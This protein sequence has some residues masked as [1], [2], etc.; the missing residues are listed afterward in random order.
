ML[1]LLCFIIAISTSS[2]LAEVTAKGETGFNLKIS[3]AVPVEPA[4]AY[5]QFLKVDEWW[6]KGHTWFG[7]AENLSIDASAGGCFCEIDGE[8]QVHHML[9]TFVDPSRRFA[10]LEVDGSRRSNL[11]TSVA[12]LVE[13]I[14]AGGGC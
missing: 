6:I 10:D 11:T 9:V 14:A 2:A 5:N 1:R 12:V 13:R 7:S 3:R 4:A 8:R